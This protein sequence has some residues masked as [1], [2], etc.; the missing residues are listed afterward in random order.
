MEK[1]RSPSR[2]GFKEFS[3][4]GSRP[5]I[6]ENLWKT[7]KQIPLYEESNFFSTVELEIEAYNPRELFAYPCDNENGEFVQKYANAK[8][9]GESD[10]DVTC[11]SGSCNGH[12]Y[13][14]EI[15]SSN[16]EFQSRRS[17]VMLLDQTLSCS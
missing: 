10:K 9:Y 5:E 15:V 12:V 6:V 14:T 2:N 4:T 8:C 7:E 1:H 3:M 13:N 16:R 11:D 17:W